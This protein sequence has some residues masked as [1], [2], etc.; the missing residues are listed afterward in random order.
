MEKNEQGKIKIILVE[1]N[2]LDALN[3]KGTFDSEIYDITIIS[4][5]QIALNFISKNEAEVDI[6]ILD[7]FLPKIT[8]IDILRQINLNEVKSA[9]IF[10]TAD[11]KIET[12]VEA[13]QLGASDFI[14]KSTDIKNQL[15][16]KVQKVYSEHIKKNELENKLRET[17]NRFTL[18]VNNLKDIVYRIR[19]VPEIKYE[20]LSPSIKD[21]L[22]YSPEEFYTDAS[23]ESN[24]LKQKYISIY[25]DLSSNP[26][27]F[28]KPLV[29]TWKRKDNEKVWI[30]HINTPVLDRNNK[31]IAIIGTGRDITYQIK[32]EESLENAKQFNE[33]I[34]SSAGEGIVVYNSKFQYIVWNKF[35]EGYTG[36]MS[37]EVIGKNA[38]DIFPH[39]IESGIGKLINRAL[40]GEYCV[41]NDT[42]FGVEKTGKKGWYFGT[43]APHFNSHKKIIGV[44]GTIHDLTKRKKIEENLKL[45]ETMY[46]MLSE[47]TSDYFYSCIKEDDVVNIDWM[48]GAYESITGYN[49]EEIKDIGCWLFFVHKDD[50]NIAKNHVYKLNA[51]ETD[52]CEFRIVTKDNKIRWIKDLVKCVYDEAN[53][54]LRFYGASKDIT[55]Q[56]EAEK[57]LI[58]AEKKYK[59]IFNHT[60]EGIFQTSKDDII[61]TVN[62]AFAKI[63]GYE[64]PEDFLS[65]N[66]KPEELY[67][68]PERHALF[69]QLIEKHKKINN[70]ESQL[71]CKDKKIIWAS[72]NA[73]GAYNENGEL[74]F[75][76]GTILDI[77][78]RKKAEEQ[79][80]KLTTAIEQSANLIIITDTKGNI[81]Y[82]NPKFTEITGYSYNEVI[83]KNS[84]IL[85][86]GKLD[87]V[88]YKNMW[89]TIKTGNEW[90][91]EFYNKKKNGEYYWEIASIAPVKDGAGNITNFIAIKED[92]TERK[93]YEQVLKET[94]A[95]AEESDRLKSSFLAN[96]SHEIRTPLNAVLGFSQLIAMDNNISET[97][98][99]YL[100]IINNSGNNLLKII[101]DIIDLSKIEAGQLKINFEECSLNLLL[102]ELYNFYQS[103][104]NQISKQDIKLFVDCSLPN[105]KNIIYIDELRLKQIMTNLINNALKFTKKG[106]ISFGYILK[107]SKT[108]QFYVKDTGKGIKKENLQ[109]IFDQFRQEDETTT[110]QYGGTGLGLAISK[111]LVELMG[112]E[113]WVESDGNQG[114]TFYFTL[115]FKSVNNAINDFSFKSRVINYDFD[116]CQKTILI[117]DDDIYV[118]IYLDNILK[119]TK[120]KTIYAKNGIDAID[121][122]KNNKEIDII[123]MDIQMPEMNGYDATKKIKETNKDL[124]VIAQTAYVFPEDRKKCLDSGCSDL[125][126]KPINAD[127][128]INTLAKFLNK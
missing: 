68:N 111:Q 93:K 72:E 104:R 16:H 5:G 25:N 106:S 108:L 86:S 99:N 127:I 90:K 55:S 30:E 47:L 120:I 2:E 73:H 48:N 96:M 116:W 58:N 65:K 84:R 57:K 10:V 102:F 20:Y 94:V 123:L 98:K 8:G 56:K 109:F 27:K 14:I 37:S 29:I 11:S 69:I 17:E 15:I 13:M 18:L 81:E 76:E 7:N 59:D 35:M 83:G 38:F 6:I 121:K 54:T 74:L 31:I 117:V 105:D 80:I 67:V 95:K 75:Y 34:I 24:Y 71:Y 101:N 126:T 125:I 115:P 61:I 3:I 19:F 39:L 88:F 79:I 85:K 50:F 87:T 51:N 41:S 40:S 12:A 28:G 119:R 78:K 92:I 110:R 49:F 53:K 60:N 52:A 82:V 112:G 118:F 107:D 70:F 100:E 77:T 103:Y 122:L 113:I 43:Y 124:P 23:L 21:I 64:S 33:E 44:I 63:L 62:D 128:L 9:I 45:S 42:Y 26:D 114:S 66:I 89:D 32:T 91:G 22:G 36:L 97:N 46:K 1:D 4:D